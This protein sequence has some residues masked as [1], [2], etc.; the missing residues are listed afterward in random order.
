MKTKICKIFIL[1]LVL[2]S[3]QVYAQ[4]KNVIPKVWGKIK[5]NA[6]GTTLPFGVLAGMEISLKGDG[7]DKTIKEKNELK[8]ALSSGEFYFKDV[9][10]NKSMV[11][12]IKYDTPSGKVAQWCGSFKFSIPKLNIIQ[13]KLNKDKAYKIAGYTGDFKCFY[14][15]GKI[16][17]KNKYE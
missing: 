1:S 16:E 7:Y 4:K 11:L 2:L 9:P 13:K 5:I 8:A 15:S 12:T 10:V 6:A 3:F 14:P 17:Y